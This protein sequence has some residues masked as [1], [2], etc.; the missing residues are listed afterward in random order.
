MV[1]PV[2]EFRG[3]VK[4]FD[5][6][7]KPSIKALDGLSFEVPDEENG[8]FLALIGPSGSGKSTILNLIAGLYGPTSGQV[9]CG[10]SS[11]EGPNDETVTVQQSYTCFPWL[12]VQQNVEFGLD[13]RGIEEAERKR[14]AIEYLERV[15][16]ADRRYAH[17]KELSGGMQQRVAIARALAL[18]RPIILM[19]EPFGALDAQTRATMQSM[20][21]NL[22]QQE[23]SLIVFVTHDINEALL[24]A[25]RILVLSSRPAQIVFDV[26][27]P[28]R[29]PRTDIA[30]RDP[31]FLEMAQTILTHLRKP[32]KEG[33]QTG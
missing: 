27:V 9:L 2:L 10:G 25:D 11:V 14:V 3:V 1:S 21:I 30:M 32:L 4:E 22:W 23:R 6:P 12:T 20:L 16:L 28:F 15:G 17:P 7:G 18:K 19:D 24:L 26:K 33:A 31:V 13:I 5:V 29:R 8:E